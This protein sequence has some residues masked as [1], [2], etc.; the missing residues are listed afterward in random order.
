MTSSAVR[1]KASPYARKLARER[2]LA[3]DAIIGTGPFGRIV[4]A[5]VLNTRDAPAVSA[6]ASARI[7]SAFAAEAD[8]S[9][10]R[11]LIADVDAAGVALSIEDVVL[12]SAVRALAEIELP[13]ALANRGLTLET[14]GRQVRLAMPGDQSVGVQRWARLEALDSGRDDVD[15]DAVLSVQFL[16][17]GR[18][19]PVFMPLLPGRA[20]RLMATGTGERLA[21]L[22]CVDTDALSAETAIAL[23]ERFTG[24]LEQP[25]SL[26]A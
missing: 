13:D 18:V 8:L 5:D 7:P 11:R 14:G 19:S 17:A 20:L 22:L 2:S 12:R 21:V 1:L 9:V 23:L 24:M 25:L 4:A 26:L 10:L 3:L 16:E 15:A 6:A